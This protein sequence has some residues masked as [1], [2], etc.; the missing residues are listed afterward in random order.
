MLMFVRWGP[1]FEADCKEPGY[2]HQI[3]TLDLYRLVQAQ[4]HR[5]EQVM[6]SP[7]RFSLIR[8]L[9]DGNPPTVVLR[10]VGRM[11]IERYALEHGWM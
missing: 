11:D 2:V 6:G 4:G 9:Q 8:I 1:C 10:E 3:K 5:I 7:V